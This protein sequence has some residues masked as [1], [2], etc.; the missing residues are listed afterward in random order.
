[1]TLLQVK[2]ESLKDLFNKFNSKKIQVANYPDSI[3][4]SALHQ[5]AKEPY[6]ATCLKISLSHMWRPHN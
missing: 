4:V 1:M 5:A 6:V 2:D 3:I